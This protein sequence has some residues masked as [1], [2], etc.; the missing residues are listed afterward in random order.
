MEELCKVESEYFKLFSHPVRLKILEILRHE[1]ACVCH[2]N[3][4]LNLRQA[5]VSQQL[6]VLREGGLIEDRKC[7]WNVYYRVV[8]PRI[9]EIIDQVVDL[10][11]P[12]HRLL[13]D[14]LLVPEDCPCPRC[15]H[16]EC[17]D[18]NTL[19]REKTEKV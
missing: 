9:Y 10:I 11:D 13:R 14:P 16:E 5:Y 15:N 7:G 8:D 19:E 18:D 6:A 12:E 1:D 4:I 2:I 17:P 3:A